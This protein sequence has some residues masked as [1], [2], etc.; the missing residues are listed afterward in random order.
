MLA[1][2]LA[3]GAGLAAAPEPAD[4]SIIYTNPADDTASHSADPGAPDSIFINL[5]NAG[6]AELI[7]SATG[8]AQAG[9]FPSGEAT[10]DIAGVAQTEV[11]GTAGQPSKLSSGTQIGPLSSF[12]DAS[13]ALLM[14]RGFYSTAGEIGEQS[15][16]AGTMGPWAPSATGSFL[17][18][19]F[20]IAG[21]THFGWVRRNTSARASSVRI[22]SGS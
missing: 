8:K 22:A 9:V 12:L 5:N 6:L 2:T 20:E 3:A 18:V 13:P 17:G 11:V 10:L 19:T 7:L 4:A 16:S 14:A 15:T 21:E 1:Y